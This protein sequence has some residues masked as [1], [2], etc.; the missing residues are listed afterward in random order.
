M[1][2]KSLPRNFKFMLHPETVENVVF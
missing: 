1:F 2:H